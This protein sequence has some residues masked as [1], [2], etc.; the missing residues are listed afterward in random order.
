MGY[1]G[2]QDPVRDTTA[3]FSIAGIGGGMSLRPS[4]GAE[5]PPRA[6]AIRVTLSRWKLPEFIWGCAKV[7]PGAT[8]TVTASYGRQPSESLLV[9]SAGVISSANGYGCQNRQVGP[10]AFLYWM[11]NANATVIDVRTPE[12]FAAGHIAGAINIPVSLFDSVDNQTATVEGLPSDTALLF[13]CTTGVASRRAANAT[14]GL[15]PE[16]VLIINLQDGIGS[17]IAAGYPLVMS[18]T[19]GLTTVALPEFKAILDFEETYDNVMLIDVRPR[20]TFDADHIPGAVSIPVAMFDDAEQL[21]AAVAMLHS[22]KVLMFYC[23]MGAASLRAAQA[24][25]AS[26]LLPGSAVLYNLGGGFNDWA[27][28]GYTVVPTLAADVINE[29]DAVEFSFFGDADSVLLIDVRTPALF[30]NS[31]IKGALNIPLGLF[32]TDIFAVL[33]QINATGAT[34]LLFY[35]T[36]GVASRA[37]ANATLASGLLPEG[38]MVV[39][40]EEGF[41]SYKA[42][43]YPYVG[44]KRV[45]AATFKAVLDSESAAD[46]VYLVDVRLLAQWTLSHIPSA[47]NI[48]MI[49]FDDASLFNATVSALPVDKVLMFYCSQGVISQHAAEKSVASGILPVDVVIYV[50]DG[51]YATWTGAGY[52]VEALTPARM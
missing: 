27:D 49:N 8:Y 32:T 9:A 5:R 4:G 34:N 52:P 16:D 43:G 41:D 14:L 35:C 46:N 1:L 23:T 25:I 3:S 37:A 17:W 38:T 30:A 44:V 22:G 10:M 19:P 51:G 40:L 31:H 28:A 39:H 12:M 29:V 48:P 24:A 15:L 20:A 26:G 6:H 45:V 7:C 42:T 50:L 47:V 21:P 18:H 36:M 11:D 33:G 2:H 13:Y